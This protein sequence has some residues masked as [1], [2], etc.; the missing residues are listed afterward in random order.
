[1]LLICDLF[2]LFV[3]DSFVSLST[4]CP[5]LLPVFPLQP[6]SVASLRGRGE[7]QQSL[8][9][10]QLVTLSYA[11]TLYIRAGGSDWSGRFVSRSSMQRLLTHPSH[12]LGHSGGQKVFVRGLCSAVTEL[13]WCLQE[14]LCPWTGSSSS[15]LYCNFSPCSSEN[16]ELLVQ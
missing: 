13:L 9:H 11:K 10:P 15:F 12:H 3:F 14:E 4:S 2:Y 5:T 1:M 8:T 7:Y 6:C 16:C